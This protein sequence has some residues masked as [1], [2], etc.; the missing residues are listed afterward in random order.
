MPTFKI[1]VTHSPPFD[2]GAVDREG[3][4]CGWEGLDQAARS[5]SAPA[6]LAL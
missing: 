2:P 6:D 4:G 3:R 1:A 5:A